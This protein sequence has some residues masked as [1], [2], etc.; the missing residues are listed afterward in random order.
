MAAV[1]AGIVVVVVVAIAAVVV[2]VVVGGDEGEAL[3]EV[4]REPAG[5]PGSDPFTDSVAAA[6]EDTG[7]PPEEAGGSTAGTALEVAST[8][9]SEPGLYGGTQNQATCDSEQLISFLDANPS[10]AEAWASV[11]GITTEEIPAFIRSLT[12]TRLRYDTRVTNHGYRDGQATS[13]QS[14]LQAGTAVLVDDHGLPRARCACGNPLLAPQA[15]TGVTYQG[16]TWSGFSTQNVQVVVSVQ[17]V[18]Q[19]VLVDINAGSQFTRP[20]GSDGSDDTPAGQEGLDGTWAVRLD[21]TCGSELGSGGTTSNSATE[22]WVFQGDSATLGVPDFFAFPPSPV[23]APL[24]QHDGEF[25]VEVVP[26]D[27]A[28]MNLNGTVTDDGTQIQGSGMAGNGTAA[29]SCAFLFVGQRGQSAPA[30]ASPATTATST[31]ATRQADS[32]AGSPPCTNEALQQALAAGAIPGTVDPDHG[33][34]CEGGFAAVGIL[35]PPYVASL[36]IFRADGDQWAVVGDANQCEDR[37]IPFEIRVWGC[38]GDPT[39]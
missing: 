28:G 8:P 21:L 4:F 13:V 1:I 31:T 29:S 39:P 7:I 25:T 33:A 27:F 35:D 24:V 18:T 11:E 34:R 38:N 19:F 26:S 3:N 32:P 17:V 22:T 14:V 36:A 2:I 20:V 10:K 12:P 15:L 23:E 16:P 37:T 30:A 6:G 9:G 5:E